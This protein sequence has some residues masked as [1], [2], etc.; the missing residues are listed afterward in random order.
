MT[1]K[2]FCATCEADLNLRDMTLSQGHDT[3]LGH[4]QQFCDILWLWPRHR[5]WSCD[6]D[7]EILQFQIHVTP[8]DHGQ[9]L[10]EIFSG[11]CALWPWPWGYYLGSRS[12][13]WI[14]GIIIHPCG[15]DTIFGY[16]CAVTLTFEIWTWVKVMIHLWI[17]DTFRVK[18]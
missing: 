8:L 3:S 4:R 13:S 2:Q 18:Y 1:R 17:L 7:L 12:G 9:Q 15:Q 5:F 16:V 6:L 10:C 11:P 14:W